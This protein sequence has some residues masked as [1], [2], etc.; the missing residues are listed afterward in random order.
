MQTAL[1]N[2]VQVLPADSEHNAIFQCIQGENLRDIDSI[3]HCLRGA[4]R[5]F[6]MKIFKMLR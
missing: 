2:Q 5:E 4:L 1:E 6:P 3:I